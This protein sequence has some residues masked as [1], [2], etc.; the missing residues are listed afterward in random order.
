MAT[1]IQ[2]FGCSFE[3][4]SFPCC[5]VLS[6]SLAASRIYQ[7]FTLISAQYPNLDVSRTLLLSPHLVVVARVHS[8]T[9]VS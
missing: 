1:R 3:C 8:L 2:V 7:L 6:L 5:S 9:R 4:D